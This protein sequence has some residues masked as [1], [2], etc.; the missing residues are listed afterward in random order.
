LHQF[1]ED[2]FAGV[3]VDVGVKDP[4]VVVEDWPVCQGMSRDE[5][6]R[7]EFDICKDALLRFEVHL[8]DEGVPSFYDGGHDIETAILVREAI[9]NLGEFCGE[10]EREGRGLLL[11]LQRLAPPLAI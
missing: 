1:R 7:S 2:D 5:H 10:P 6:F 3:D 4:P 9:L 8:D 11:L